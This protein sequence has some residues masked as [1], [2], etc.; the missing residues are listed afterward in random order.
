MFLFKLYLGN[1]FLSIV[2]NFFAMSSYISLTLFKA[3]LAAL[4][5]PNVVDAFAVLNSFLIV[6]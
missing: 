3:S 4:V 5:S 6:L 2:P 1:F